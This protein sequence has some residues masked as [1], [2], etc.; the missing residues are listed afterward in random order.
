MERYAYR[1]GEALTVEISVAPRRPIGDFVFGIGLFTPE[2]LCVHGSNTDID[3]FEPERLD[4]P[5]TVRVTLPHCD[6]GAGTYL[7]DVAVHSR[8][9]TPYDYWRGACRFRIDSPVA[10]A[11]VYRPER[12]WSA[13]GA[14]RWGS[15]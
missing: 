9:E 5:A 4:G 8:R 10:D 14:L 13:S 3:G 6:L 2:D 15:R 1:S 11:G 7:L 12:I